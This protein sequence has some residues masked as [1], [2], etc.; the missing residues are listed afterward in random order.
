[1]ASWLVKSLPLWARAALRKAKYHTMGRMSPSAYWNFAA[2]ISATAAICTDCTN[3][4]RFFELGRREAALIRRLGLLGPEVRALDIGCGIGRVERAI[5]AEVD[6]IIG[7]DVS[8]RMVKL[9]RRKV[10]ARNVRFEVG[11][12]CALPGIPS[13]WLDLCFSFF[14]F[15]HV[16]RPVAK[17]YFGEVARVLKEGG[18]FLFQ[19]PTAA[20]RGE[21]PPN[22]PFGMRY[23]TMDAVVE[24]LQGT[25]LVLQDRFDLEGRS[26][27]AKEAAVPLDQYFL[28][29]R[30]D[31]QSG[32]AVVL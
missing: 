9:A 12:G 24:L 1:M 18:H 4:G 28:A 20:D 22:H 29:I 2:S 15:Q 3:E 17:G 19:L 32:S 13:N 14:V 5:F 31:L 11:D 25:G 16:P 10:T 6:S 21:P 23:Y 27:A 30:H 8:S 7:I 26:L